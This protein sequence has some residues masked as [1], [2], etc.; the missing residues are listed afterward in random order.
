MIVGTQVIQRVTLAID[1]NDHDPLVIH[2]KPTHRIWCNV[3]DI[4]YGNPLRHAMFIPYVEGVIMQKPNSTLGLHHL[5]L[6]VKNLGACVNFYTNL[7]GMKIVWQPDN[8]NVYLSSGNDN[9]ALHRAKESFTRTEHQALDH[10]GF[11]LKTPEDVDQWHD[12]LR[13][14]QV[15][16][17]AAPKN[18]RDGARSFY[19]ADPEGNAVQMIYYPM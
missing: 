5:A 11:F 9:L 19:C 6:S 14:H 15:T 18:H 17:K 1:I 13:A 7:L 12:Y 8:D 16:I 4:G 2:G 10:L 3:I